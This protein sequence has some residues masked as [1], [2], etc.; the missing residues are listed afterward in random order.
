M[1]YNQND[2]VRL[3][4]DGKSVVI[5]DQTKL[6]GEK[7]LLTLNDEAE[8]FDAIISL[9]VRGAPAIGIFA[10]Y[11]LY[12]LACRFD[13]GEDFFER[14]E[15][16]AEYLNSA[17]PTAVNLSY[18]LDRVRNAALSKAG[19]G[20]QEILETMKG[21]AEKIHL[22]DIESCERMSRYGLSLVKSGDGILTH[23]NAGA[24]ATSR[25]GT[26]LGPLLYGAER[27][28]KFHA[29]I[30]ETRPLLQG[31]RLTAYELM[32]AGIDCTLICDN[33][34]GLVMS[35]GKIQAC[36]AGCDRAAVNGDCANKIGTLSVA[37]LADY[38]KI[39]FYIFC[40]TSTIDVNCK[41]GADIVIEERKPEEIT[42]LYFD[43][44]IAPE[45][46]NCYNPAFDVTPNSLITAIIT[47]KGII[48]RGESI[49][50]IL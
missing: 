49:E 4:P 15:K 34:A 35:Q 8:M 5:I 31:S 19:C 37:V 44:Q 9:K 16:T 12:V 1:I 7:K 50:K 24:L 30:D 2:S 43:R 26:A 23:C 36:F 40:P 10:G 27:G 38:Y 42:S 3:S 45:G 28:Y 6:P 14:L 21:E 48:R 25:Y 32:S 18:A 13:E 41:T 46:I 20:R 39:P 29:Y 33:M 11:A 47:E 22:E 17:R